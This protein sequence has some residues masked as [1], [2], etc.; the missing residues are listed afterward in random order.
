MTQQE[1]CESK[2]SNEDGADETEL[3]ET[4]AASLAILRER[5]SSSHKQKA[6]Q[7]CVVKAQCTAKIKKDR[8]SLI[9]ETDGLESELFAQFLFPDD[10]DQTSKGPNRHMLSAKQGGMNAGI[11]T[12]AELNEK[13]AA[14][15]QLI[16]EKQQAELGQKKTWEPENKTKLKEAGTKASEKQTKK[17]KQE[18]AGKVTANSD[19]VKAL[20]ASSIKTKK[21]LSAKLKAAMEN[22]KE[23][24]TEARANQEA[25]TTKAKDASAK[26]TADVRTAM[27]ANYTK[28]AKERSLKDAK[29]SADMRKEIDSKNNAKIAAQLKEA[30]SKFKIKSE[31]EKKLQ[32][33]DREHMA[34]VNAREDKQKKEI[35]HKKEKAVSASAKTMAELQ[36]V[37]LAAISDCVT[38][39]MP[40]CTT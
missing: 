11:T 37:N 22:N 24:D 27:A 13:T 7:C 8:L 30:R 38:A 18:S 19:L 21:Q 9:D 40:E 4:P 36:G 25:L 32:K 2:L 14:F 31:K 6:V 5:Q 3:L 16:Q 33:K 35:L 39:R 28:T 23:H 1:K 15:K 17:V 10:E 12:A 26:A 29:K 20:A 34:E